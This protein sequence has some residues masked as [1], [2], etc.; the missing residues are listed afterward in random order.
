M[1]PTS[2]PCGLLFRLVAEGSVAPG[3]KFSPPITVP[4]RAE[5]PDQLAVPESMTATMTPFPV[6]PAACSGEALMSALL[7]L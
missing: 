2:V 6:W 7:K 1:V 3:T 4:D 5:T